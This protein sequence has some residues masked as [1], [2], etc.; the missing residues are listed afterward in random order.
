M[1]Q[2]TQE[3]A[4]IGLRRASRAVAASSRRGQPRKR[5][6]V[7]ESSPAAESALD[8]DV[9]RHMDAVLDVDD[10]ID[11]QL[12]RME[13]VRPDDPSFDWRWIQGAGDEANGEDQEGSESADDLDEGSEPQRVEVPGEILE[14][15]RGA[16]ARA[17]TEPESHAI[18]AV[19]RSFL[20]DLC[21][22]T[23]TQAAEMATVEGLPWIVSRN[24]SIGLGVDLKH[25]RKSDVFAY[26]LVVHAWLVVCFKV[27]Q[28]LPPPAFTLVTEMSS[29]FLSAHIIMQ[30]SLSTTY[31]EL[32][33]AVKYWE[34]RPTALSKRSPWQREKWFQ[35]LLQVDISAAH[36]RNEMAVAYLQALAKGGKAE[37]AA[38]I[39]SKDQQSTY[40]TP[41]RTF[42]QGIP[43]HLEWVLTELI[44]ILAAMNLEVIK[45][46]IDGSLPRKAE[47][48][49]TEVSNALER[50]KDQRPVPPAI[51]MN[52]ICDPTGISPTPRQWLE[53]YIFM[54]KYVSPGKE[55]D[56]LAAIVDQL[57]HPEERWPVTLAKKGL[58]RYTEWRT[59]VEMDGDHHPNQLR[60]RMVQYFA[61]EMQVRVG[62]EIAEGRGHIPLA[63]PV[64]EIGFSINWQKRLREHRHHQNS[65]YLMNLAEA[66]FRY[67]YPESFRLQQLVIYTCYTP[68][69]CWFS[70]VI[71]TQLGQGYT[72]AAA[73]F[74]H[75]PAGRSNGS[76]YKQTAKQDWNRFEHGATRSGE[77]EEEL[78][79]I[80]SETRRDVLVATQRHREAEET[81]GKRKELLQG[82]DD[83]LKGVLEWSRAASR[84]QEQGGSD[85]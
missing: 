8:N 81:Q 25:Q 33:M 54:F 78:R 85:A 37:L 42:T 28:G 59:F 82:L 63:A 61:S 17:A 32:S 52:T 16:L 26:G 43:T 50:L 66:L 7:V 65:N 38:E 67:L 30:D 13:D 76:A 2:W 14:A 22:R 56:D 29:Y 77:I 24:R 60:R 44:S 6:Y 49:N 84:S 34:Q 45:A 55:S 9:T 64:T 23:D 40:R 21:S 57:I 80:A 12:E 73:G 31:E 75:Y 51:Y 71:L 79:E 15:E 20:A 83:A 62:N 19:Y 27:Q 36:D 68:S 3:N 53:V 1:S 11:T 74:S 4:N 5:L 41:L 48:S 39:I 58:R 70:E 35:R 18:H 10:I 47:I 69:Q 46:L 72:D